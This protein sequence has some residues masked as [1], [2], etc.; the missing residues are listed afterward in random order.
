MPDN[1]GN[2]PPSSN[3]AWKDWPQDKRQTATNLLD[4]DDLIPILKTGKSG[5]LTNGQTFPNG[6]HIFPGAGQ[7]VTSLPGPLTVTDNLSQ[8]TPSPSPEPTP[9][10]EPS[11]SPSPSPE[12]HLPLLSRCLVHHPALSLHLPLLLSSQNLNQILEL[13]GQWMEQEA[14]I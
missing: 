2:P 11:P 3:L 14:R 4:D 7:P 1:G 13:V 12:L 5:T 9:S 6:I 8:P 10:P